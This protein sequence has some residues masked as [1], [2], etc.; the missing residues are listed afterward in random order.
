LRLVAW[1]HE[2]CKDDVG[3]AGGKGANLGELTR[4]GIPVP[5][6]LVVTS[7]AYFGFLE[8]A[9][10]GPRI[11]QLLDGLDLAD[12]AALQRAAAGIKMLITTADMPPEAAQE[13]ARAYEQMDCGHVAVRSSATAEDLAEASFAGQQ[14]TYLNVLGEEAVIG[15]VRE[16]WASLFESQAIFYRSRAGFDHLAVGIAVVVQRMVQSERSGVMFTLQPVSGDRTQIVIEAIYGLGEAVVSGIV[17][18]DMYIV[19]KGSLEI[20]E[21]MVVKQDRELVRNPDAGQGAENNCWRQIDFA[22]AGAQK[23]T[24]EQVRELAALGMQVEAHYGKPQDIEW[25]YE[26]GEFLLVQARPVTTAGG[27]AL[28]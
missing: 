17:T 4:A 21:K 22:L 27:G 11:A 25:A 1:F 23:L 12:N 9:G 24:D 8:Q 16:C 26:G 5:P 19:Q 18:P 7:G 14:S 28:G 2:V 6:G 10:L 15:A 20:V 3:T 13:I